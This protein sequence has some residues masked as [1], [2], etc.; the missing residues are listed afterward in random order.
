MNSALDPAVS[1]PPHVPSSPGLLI[2]NADDWGRDA[3][4]TDS[5]LDCTRNGAVSSVSAMV[6][7]EDSERA[8]DIAR[9]WDIDAGLHLNLTT[10]FS[11][12]ACPSR[13]VE[14]QLKLAG[15]LRGHRL[16]Q[17]LFHPGLARTFAYVV[18]AQLDEFGRLYGRAP[19]RIDGHHHMHLCANVLLARLLPSG[20]L[21]RRNFSFQPGE[22][23]R[24]NIL[25]RRLV[26]RLVARRHR[27]VDFFF[28]LAPLEPAHRLA[29]IFSLARQS[30]VEVEAHPVNPDEYRFLAEGEILRE[31]GDV[32]MMRPSDMPPPTPTVKPMPSQPKVRS[33]D[34][35]DLQIQGRS[36]RSLSAPVDG[37]TV[38]VAGR[39]IKIAAVK[40]EDLVEGG[41]VEDPPAFVARLKATGLK[42][43]IFTFAQ[44]LP[45]TVPRYAYHLEWDNLAVIPVTTFAD[46]WDGRVESSVRRAV[47]KANKVGVVTKEIV[48]DDA[49]VDGIAAIYNESPI[50]Q[51]RAFWHYQ[52]D[53]ETVRGENSTYLER[54]TFI[55]A[56]YAEELIGFM[57]MIHVDKIASIVQI[58]SKIKHSDK[59]P[60]NALIAKAVEV[61]EQK[62]VSHVVY[63]SYIYND[64]HSSLTEFK[65]RNGFQ[66]VLLPRYY[67]PL[68][69]HGRIALRLRLHRDL[70]ERVPKPV[71]AQ[72]LRLR[73]S[74]N[75]RRAAVAKDTL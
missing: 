50:R 66:Q 40:D 34:H 15:Y 8:A 75:E 58:L 27:V 69:L 38:V 14:R 16:S 3:L 23:S 36:R 48:F 35:T 63:C 52:K 32:R 26:D 74:W 7:M 21:V 65:R 33:V 4:T 43:D 44:T 62:R 46:W 19:D 30:I 61:C 67:V 12:P 28:S 6:F 51:G 56:Y 57:R 53:L 49:L 31:A 24:A 68:T 54:S 55:G 37:R 73:K 18:A 70:V 17:V 45:D 42:A 5:T 60:T 64:P 71:L 9:E 22:K 20:T 72:L 10:A 13:L 47:R 59:R 11:A 1:D 29:R 2:V 41:A 25:Y 39:W